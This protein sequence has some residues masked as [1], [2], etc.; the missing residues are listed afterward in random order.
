M[1][2]GLTF[3]ALTH[4]T[5]CLKEGPLTK[6]TEGVWGSCSEERKKGNG[7]KHVSRVFLNHDI[8][9]TITGNTRG[10]AHRHSVAATLGSLGLKQMPESKE[11]GK[12]ACSGT[13]S[14]D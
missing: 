1:D 3:S 13:R 11:M 4:S 7:E 8:Q 10:A 14:R 2:E 5:S 9:F 12:T 6:I